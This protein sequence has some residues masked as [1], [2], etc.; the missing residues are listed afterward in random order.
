MAVSL[1]QSSVREIQTTLNLI[2]NK[3]PNPSWR[4][5]AVD[6]QW[7]TETIAAVQKFQEFAH[8]SVDGIPGPQTWGALRSY[9]SATC[10]LSSAP[11]GHTLAKPSLN[12]NA[13]ASLKDTALKIV[14]LVT[15]TASDMISNMS[16]VVEEMAKGISDY[17]KVNPKA[18]K[19]SYV[20]FTSRWDSRM[21]DLRKAVQGFI[22]NEEVIARNKPLANSSHYPSNTG[23]GLQ[24]LRAKQN[25]SQAQ[26]L[27]NYYGKVKLK[28]SNEIL[29]EIKKYDF[30][31][32]VDRYLKK[33]GITGEI[34]LDR[35]GTAFK[36]KSFKVSAGGTAMLIF[37][38]K[39]VLW[40]LVQIKEW[41][42]EQWWQDLKKDLYDFFDGLVMAFAAAVIA[43]IVA[44][45]IAGIAAAL[46][47]TISAGWIVVIVA[48]LAIIIASIFMYLLQEA[49]ISFTETAL[50]GYQELY[51]LFI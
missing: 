25:I 7:G 8:L 41:G 19:N 50:Q 32:K 46:G 26:R 15:N 16:A 44:A 1:S 5:V 42:T 31:S 13:N 36:G 37:S 48:A 6:G 24:S 20:H 4:M 30:V 45:V 2:R 18:L 10:F 47:F 40:D 9:S 38:L 34:R 22:N 21:K 29:A 51:R 35:L 33:M 39:D 43:Q 3:V 49:D 12:Y 27:Q 11:Q 28:K 23:N 14:T 17:S